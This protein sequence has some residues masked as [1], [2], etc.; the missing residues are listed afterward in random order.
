MSDNGKNVF[1]RA[2]ITLPEVSFQLRNLQFAVVDYSNCLWFTSGLT[3]NRLTVAGIISG[4]VQTPG[5]NVVLNSR[6]TTDGFDI[7]S[8]C[9]QS[10]GSISTPT[11]THTRT[12]T[13][14]DD[15]TRSNIAPAL[16]VM[17][18]GGGG[19]GQARDVTVMA[20]L[21]AT[22]ESANYT[23]VGAGGKPLGPEQRSRWGRVKWLSWG[24]IFPVSCFLRE[25]G[26]F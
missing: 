10:P 11:D 4:D 17:A 12:H 22:Q 15:C 1:P 18:T 3:T 5:D 24:P 19:G 8:E 23:S 7:Q 21:T 26:S 6:K 16:V 25:S 2:E 14:S 13:P 20:P 9:E